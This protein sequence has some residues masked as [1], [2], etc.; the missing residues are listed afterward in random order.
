VSIDPELSDLTSEWQLA[1]VRL[2]RI[3]ANE[4]LR[5][6]AAIIVAMVAILF[7]GPSIEWIRRWGLSP[8]I[9]SYALL[10]PLLAA[11]WVWIARRRLVMPEVDQIRRELRIERQ[12]RMHPLEIGERDPSV[13]DVLVKQ[14]PIVDQRSPLLLAAAIALDTVAFWVRDPTLTFCSFL[15][16]CAGIVLYR[17]GRL[18]LRS[19]RTP[20]LIM[21]AMIPLPAVLLD[22]IMDREQPALLGA[23]EHMVNNVKQI[24]TLPQDVAPLT[25]TSGVSHYT[26]FPERDGLAIS[27]SILV[28][29]VLL[30]YLS[31]IRTSTPLPKIGVTV[32]TALMCGTL[33]YARLIL[34]CL[35]AAYDKESAAFIETLSIYLVYLLDFGFLYLFIRGFHCVRYHRWVSFSPRF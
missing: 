20:L 16:T 9:Q 27:G 8:G 6:E 12:T 35:V 22:G 33:V 28:M 5:R 10:S 32:A 17:N 13:L 21:C 15:L 1:R 11:A 23:V 34:L 2:A 24:A 14:P 7:A 4:P 18:A 26:F 30:L 19:I 31:F 25:I 29:V 3:K